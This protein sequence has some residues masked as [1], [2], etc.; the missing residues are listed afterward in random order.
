MRG[1]VARACARTGTYSASTPIFCSVNLYSERIVAATLEL[2][3][4]W[5]ELV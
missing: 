3:L 4:G 2:S 5:K 1:G